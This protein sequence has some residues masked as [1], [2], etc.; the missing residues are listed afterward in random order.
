MTVQYKFGEQSWITLGGRVLGILN[1]TYSKSYGIE[2]TTGKDEWNWHIVPNFRIQHSKGMNRLSMTVMGYSER[3]SS[4]RMLPVLNITDPSRLSLGNVYLRPYTQ[5]YFSCDWTRNNTKKFSNLMVYL[6]GQLNDSPISYARWY[7]ADGILYSIPVN[8]RKPGVTAT[9]N[10]NYTTPLDAKKNWSLTL[11]GYANYVS[12]VSYQARTTLPGLDKDNFDYSSFM[13][14]FW[15]NAA[16]D[17]F[18]GG[19]SGFGES[20]TRSFSPN[21]TISVRYNKDRYSFYLMANTNGYI[22]RYSLDP[23]VNMNTLDTHLTASGS[24]I[25]KHEFEFDTD[26]AYV[27]YKGYAN[28]YGQPE[29]RWNAE[30]SKN[31]GALNLSLTI[32][33]ILNQTTNLTHTVTAN[34]EE[35]SYRLIMGRY[36]LFGIKWNFGKM[37]ASHSQRASDAMWNML[38]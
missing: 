19:K 20:L 24:Y 8:S 25:S 27:F 38:F 31:I 23:S 2:E 10:A 26:I 33:D 30:I 28:G 21:A 29:W 16:G 5:T 18:Y 35:D 9:V 34:Y 1:E 32:H 7:D 15:G 13:A 4:S 11:S 37:N 6:F 12:S 22:V 17:R 36:F 3:P 14:E